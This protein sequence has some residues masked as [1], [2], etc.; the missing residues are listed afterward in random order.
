M[1]EL[2]DINPCNYINSIPLE[3]LI[4][5]MVSYQNNLGK[6]NMIQ[7]DPTNEDYFPCGSM[8]VPFDQVI[9]LVTGINDC[10]EPAIRYGAYSDSCGNSWVDCANNTMDKSM[11]GMALVGKSA[12]GTAFLRLNIQAL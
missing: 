4:A 3:M 2:G 8:P 1:A 7:V 9:R 10:N 12:D 11:I 5:S 6:L